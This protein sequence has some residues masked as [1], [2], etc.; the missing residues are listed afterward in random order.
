MSNTRKR[1]RTTGMVERFLFLS[2][3][4]DVEATCK[5]AS[6]LAK[7]FTPSVAKSWNQ[8]GKGFQAVSSM[9]GSKS[10][11]EEKTVVRSLTSVLHSDRDPGSQSSEEIAEITWSSSDSDLSGGELLMN[12]SRCLKERR[13]VLKGQSTENSYHKYICMINSLADS[14]SS[15]E[16]IPAID[17]DSLS[18]KDATSD[19]IECLVDPNCIDSDTSSSHNG[20]NRNYVIQQSE[21]LMTAEDILE[22]SSDN[23]STK[24][25]E[26]CTK[27]IPSTSA[28]PPIPNCGSE[29]GRTMRSASNWLRS[30]Q[31]FLQTP[32]KQK[33]K[34]FKTPEDSAK[35]RKK[36][37]RGGLA[38]RLNRLQ[39]RERSAIN[40]WKHQSLA[41]LQTHTGRQDDILMVKVL[42]LHEE[43]SMFIALCQPLRGTSTDHAIENDA[44]SS[45][46]PLKVLFTSETAL[47]LGICAGDSVHIYPP[48]FL[49]MEI[50]NS[51][52]VSL[53]LYSDIG[54]TVILA[55]GK[56]KSMSQR[57]LNFCGLVPLRQKLDIQDG[58]TCAILCTYFSQK[59]IT[60]TK[61]DYCCPGK[62][63][64]FRKAP[65]SLSVKFNL[66]DSR[67]KC[68]SVD[69]DTTIRNVGSLFPIPQ[70]EVM[71]VLDF[72]HHLST[73]NV[74]DSLLEVI[75][76]QGAAG[77]A[78]QN[79]KVVIQR[80]YCLPI[81]EVL[82]NQLVRN[83]Q[84]DHPLPSN[85][86]QQNA[87]LCFL[88]QDMYGL[89]GEVHHHTFCSL[90][91]DM[92][93]QSACWEGKEC[94]LTGMKVL[95]RTT[96]GRSL[97]LFSLIDSLWPPLI[98]PKVHGQ[99]QGSQESIDLITDVQLPAPSFCYVLAPLPGE[100]GIK[101]LQNENVSDL[102]RPSASHNLKHILQ[103]VPEQHRCS[104]SAEVIY[105]RFQDQTAYHQKSKDFWLFVIDSSLQ[106][107][108]HDSGVPKTLSVYVTSSCILGLEVIKSLNDETSSNIFFKDA[109]I[110][111]GFIVCA[112]GTI[113]SVNKLVLQS[114]ENERI[115]SLTGNIV[116]NELNALTKVNSLCTVQGNVVGVDEANAFSWIA[117]NRCGNGKLEKK[118]GE[119]ESFYCCLCAQSVMTPFTKMQLEVFLQYPDLPHS[120]IKIKLLE[121][122][123]SSLLLHSSSDEGGYEVDGVLGQE[124]GPLSCYVRS[125]THQPASWIGLEEVS[126]LYTQ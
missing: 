18:D 80:V 78:K 8:C 25:R 59:M 37:M 126:L 81:K 119:S 31:A 91:E 56:V 116:L 67:E 123:I 72:K 44:C 64:V 20:G 10:M 97:G 65:M 50:L 9:E 14:Q 43:C 94:Y 102:Y 86:G 34:Q 23:E 52:M 89:F 21:S 49:W 98:S 87:R 79:L 4:Q 47:H 121:P 32:D 11:G 48:C 100:G 55:L 42:D 99:S 3:D 62:S 24:E 69:Q 41:D 13:S 39:C 85:V 5:R 12:N 16:D 38:E 122:S 36:F 83:N 118:H 107:A 33:R 45:K 111:K 30:A 26:W 88:V 1:K 115:S 51:L 28:S 77:W 2:G 114:D 66:T 54:I 103:H 82:H 15:E 22:F 125:V 61:S 120:T 70:E 40:F 6:T 29:H 113:L 96:R 27:S 7:K 35:K 75:E 58:N 46:T 93:I 60:G 71:K 109:I 74:C 108:G 63:V 106:S 53:L 57:S 124:L 68:Y 84:Q 110:E 104:F 17:W 101:V 19:E 105:T 112:E 73:V 90:E 95:Q 92:Q 76:S 117:C